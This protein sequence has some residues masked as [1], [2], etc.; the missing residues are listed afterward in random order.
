MDFRENKFIKTIMLNGSSYH[1]NCKEINI[2]VYNYVIIHLYGTQNK[3][4]ISEF[5]KTVK[6][7]KDLIII[8]PESQ[9]KLSL[10]PIF[11]YIRVRNKSAFFF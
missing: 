4:A 7:F 9:K 2:K 5:V 1:L 8:F 10:Y 3:F 6:F 11:F